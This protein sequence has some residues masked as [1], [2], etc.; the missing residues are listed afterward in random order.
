M[1]TE[2]L[3]TEEEL[4]FVIFCI[5][6]LALRHRKNAAD[7][8]CAMKEK[9]DLVGNY[10]VPGYEFLHTQDKDYILDDI[11]EVMKEKS[12]DC[13][14]MRKISTLSVRVL[15]CFSFHIITTEVL[16]YDRI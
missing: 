12:K 2:G 14:R 7:V 3:K 4:A 13:D 16:C 10:I 15:I 11:E 5:E 6:N 8:Y 1:S 9:W